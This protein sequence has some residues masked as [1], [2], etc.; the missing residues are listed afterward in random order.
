MNAPET[1]DTT[2]AP[3]IVN[4]IN[5]VRQVEPRFEEKGTPEV[6]YQTVVNQID[7]LK[8]HNLPATF[9]LQYDALIDERYEKLFKERL[10]DNDEIGGWFEPV[11]INWGAP[12]KPWN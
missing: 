2:S 8:K 5:F 1:N 9:P 10:D 12:H 6:L 7:L 3:R 4:I 11:R